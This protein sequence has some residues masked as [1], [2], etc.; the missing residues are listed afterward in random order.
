MKD[1]FPYIH[2]TAVVFNPLV[3]TFAYNGSIVF[4]EHVVARMTV[5]VS[6]GRRGDLR[7]ELISPFGTTST[8]IDYRDQD[9]VT[10]DFTDWT[11]MSVRF[12]GEDPS[13]QWTLIVR[14]RSPFSPVDMSGLAMT[15]YGTDEIPEA[16][17]NIPEQCDSACAGG[18]ARAGPEYCDSCADLRNAHTRECIT[19]CPAG[20]EQRNGYCYDPTIPEPVCRTPGNI[21]LFYI[22]I[23]LEVR[24]DYVIV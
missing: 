12:W 23:I 19:E 22:Y 2:S 24:Y 7:I 10:G 5:G 21:F 6:S 15:L 20:Y 18:C 1:I 13:G 11:F 16:I 9:T 3:I 17:T 14:S 8:L 4:L